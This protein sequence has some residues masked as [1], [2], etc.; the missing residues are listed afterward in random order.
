MPETIADQIRAWARREINGDAVMTRNTDA[1]NHMIEAV[2]RL[3]QMPW[4]SRE[5]SSAGSSKDS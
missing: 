4:A 5:A 2:E 1:Y 3:V